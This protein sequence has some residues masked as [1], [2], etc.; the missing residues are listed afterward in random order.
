MSPIRPLALC[1]VMLVVAGCSYVETT[2]PPPTPAGF[3]GIASEFVRRGVQIGRSVSGD[4][5]CDDKTLA[6]TAIALDAMGL[7]QAT[8]VR[9]Y[10]YAFRDR[11]TFDRLRASVDACARAYVTDP[12]MFESVDQS[13]FVLAGQGPWAA[14]FKAALRQSLQSAAGTGN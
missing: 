10:L 3:Q 4:P 5:G 7:D 14:G 2:P 1:F 13:P 9:I 6:P 11:A 8:K 12:A